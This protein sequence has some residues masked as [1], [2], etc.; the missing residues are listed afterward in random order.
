M[1][2]PVYSY[3]LFSAI[4]GHLGLTIFNGQNHTVILSHDNAR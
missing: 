1:K 3:R 2:K 4:Y